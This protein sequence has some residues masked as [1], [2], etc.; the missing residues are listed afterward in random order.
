MAWKPPAT[1]PTNLYQRGKIIMF[2]RSKHSITLRQQK[3]WRDIAKVNR[4]TF[5]TTI[6]KDKYRETRKVGKAQSGFMFLT[7]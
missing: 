6:I 7:I 2:S 5:T 4:K 1:T 3:A